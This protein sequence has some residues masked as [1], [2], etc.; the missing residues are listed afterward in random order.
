MTLLT[1]G[2]NT[3]DL[4]EDLYREIFA[5]LAGVEMPHPLEPPAEPVDGRRGAVPGTYERASVRLDVLERD[6]MPILRTEI[7]GPLAALVPE[8][9]HEYP[10]TRST[11]ASSSSAIPTRDLDPGD[12][13]TTCL[14]ASRT[15]ISGCG[16]RR[17]P[18]SH[19]RRSP[20]RQSRLLFAATM[21]RG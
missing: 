1:N 16:R 5:E 7:T 10:M 18:L 8:T 3:R 4:Y 12:A 19:H 20:R 13:S 21:W 17:R 14:P 9:V 6:G 11:T 15:C 2:G